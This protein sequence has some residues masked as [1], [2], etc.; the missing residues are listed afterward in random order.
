MAIVIRVRISEAQHADVLELA[1][2]AG[3]SLS[4]LIRQRAVNRPVISSTYS[5]HTG[6]PGKRL[7]QLVSILTPRQES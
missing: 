5:R 3:V 6:N 1:E 7:S 2:Y 4:V